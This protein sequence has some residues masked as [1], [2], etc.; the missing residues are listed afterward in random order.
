[1]YLLEPQIN[2][3]NCRNM[4]YLNMFVNPVSLFSLLA[5]ISVIFYTVIVNFD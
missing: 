5:P 2:C 1:M 3:Y 4:C